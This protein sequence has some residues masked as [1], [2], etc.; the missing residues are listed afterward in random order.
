MSRFF[1]VGRLARQRMYCKIQDRAPEPGARQKHQSQKPKTRKGTLQSFIRIPIKLF[2]WKV[3]FSSP[4]TGDQIRDPR[5]Q[6]NL[7]ISRILWFASADVTIFYSREAV[8]TT[9][10]LQNTRQKP[11]NQFWQQRKTPKTLQ[12]SDNIICR[13]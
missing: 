3:D 2:I 13:L 6:E 7:R 11:Q 9:D 4:A 8:E 5:N 10:V 12:N 1:S